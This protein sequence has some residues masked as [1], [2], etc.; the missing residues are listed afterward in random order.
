[1]I[2]RRQRHDL[3]EKSPVEDAEATAVNSERFEL[4]ARKH[5]GGTFTPED[6]ERL[7]SLDS[8]T[9]QLVP[10]VTEE[11]LRNLKEFEQRLDEREERLREIREEFGLSHPEV[12]SPATL[13][14]PRHQ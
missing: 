4:L 3:P 2:H 11:D 14:A 1:M 9:Q 10:R 7:A 5:G 13:S 8:R 12:E 6:Q